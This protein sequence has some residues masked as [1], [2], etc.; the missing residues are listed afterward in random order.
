MWGLEPH[1]P[2]IGSAVSVANCKETS[3]L[4]VELFGRFSIFVSIVIFTLTNW[5]GFVSA[6]KV[7][8]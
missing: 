4:S 5:C 6:T 2:F 3:V 1:T 8:G 7:F